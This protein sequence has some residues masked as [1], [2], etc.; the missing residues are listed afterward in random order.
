VRWSLL[1]KLRELRVKKEELEAQVLKLLFFR[2]CGGNLIAY[3]KDGFVCLEVVNYD[4]VD[5]VRRLLDVDKICLVSATLTRSKGVEVID[6]EEGK[7]KNRIFV[8]PVVNMSYTRVKDEDFELVASW[9]SKIVKLTLSRGWGNKFVLH[10]GNNGYHA[11]KFFE[12]IKSA[13]LNEGVRSERSE[14]GKA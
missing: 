2:S 5:V 8:C 13:C 7:F 9:I 14:N 3:E 1:R 12:S 11:S 4:P 10:A 6:C